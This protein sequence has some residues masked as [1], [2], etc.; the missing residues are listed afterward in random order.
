M[1]A[2][3]DAHGRGTVLAQDVCEVSEVWL[4]AVLGSESCACACRLS[5]H[6]AMNCSAYALCTQKAH[7]MTKFKL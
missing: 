3:V 7:N 6:T 2:D 4:V 5:S 1:L